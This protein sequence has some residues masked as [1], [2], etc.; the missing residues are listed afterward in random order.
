MHC[1]FRRGDP[2]VSSSTE[3]CAG[4]ISGQ[5][6]RMAATCFT[7]ILLASTANM[8]VDWALPNGTCGRGAGCVLAPHTNHPLG[9]S[10]MSDHCQFIPK[11]QVNM[12]Y[13]KLQNLSHIVSKPNLANKATPTFKTKGSRRS[14]C[15]HT[16]LHR[17]CAQSQCLTTE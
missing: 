16:S 5:A 11:K 3:S 2:W 17:P 12:F 4:C 8:A 9:R 15:Q 6:F 13:S 7:H 14:L 1:F 10:Q